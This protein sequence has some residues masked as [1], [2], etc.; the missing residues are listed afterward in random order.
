MDLDKSLI[1]E[2]A[3]QALQRAADDGEAFFMTCACG[4]DSAG[5]GGFTPVVQ[6]HPC[7]NELQ[8]L[9]CN[10]C[11]KPAYFEEGFLIWIGDD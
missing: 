7:G 6:R 11:G 9:V 8:A 2:I 3:R 5:L 10:G 4:T 1:S